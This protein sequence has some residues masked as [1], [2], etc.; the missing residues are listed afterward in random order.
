[1]QIRSA[2]QQSV[3]HTETLRLR[4]RDADWAAAS[5]GQ[6]HC[7]GLT[8]KVWSMN[9]CSGEAHTT[10]RVKSGLP[11]AR[12]YTSL[13]SCKMTACIWCWM[14]CAQQLRFA[15]GLRSVRLFPAA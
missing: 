9:S 5:A 10:S 1:M 15:L 6:Q 3:M 2:G 14:S 7:S 4:S 8:G 13:V 12:L 11:S